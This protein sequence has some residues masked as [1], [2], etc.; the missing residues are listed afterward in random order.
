MVKNFSQIPEKELLEKILKLNEIDSFNPMQEKVLSQNL[1]NSNIVV[2]A[3]TA[4]GKTLV[5]EIAALNS[6]INNR[7]KVVYTCPLRALAN[8]HYTEFKRKYSDSLNIKATISTGDFDSSSKHL[9]NYDIIF[10]THEKCLPFDE[11][12]VCKDD[13]NLRIVKI[14]EFFEE[15]YHNAKIIKMK[16]K[17]TLIPKKKYFSVSFDFNKKEPVFSEIE[18][19]T[20]SAN[21]DK[22]LELKLQSGRMLT[23]T[24][25]HTLFRLQ[26]AELEK[27]SAEDSLGSYLTA[28]SDSSILLK[29]KINHFNVFEQFVENN[30]DNLFYVTF[31]SVNFEEL[32]NVMVTKNRT[33]RKAKELAKRYL[34][35]KRMPASIA[36]KLK[37]I[38][39]HKITLQ[40][41]D[42]YHQL[43]SK[44]KLSKSFGKILGYFISE[45]SYSTVSKTHGYYVLRYPVINKW[46]KDDLIKSLE[47][48]KIPFKLH[49]KNNELAVKSKILYHLFKSF[50]IGKAANKKLPD[51]VFFAPKPF[52]IGL[53]QGL[54]NGDGGVNPSSI[55]Y[56]TKNKELAYQIS[57]LL[58]RFRVQT[59]I[60]PQKVKGYKDTYWRLNMYGGKNIERF[61]YLVQELRPNLMKKAIELASS[62]EKRDSMFNNLPARP[63][64][65]KNQLHSMKKLDRAVYSG[66][67]SNNRVSKTLA[68]SFSLKYNLKEAL[69]ICNYP[70]GF[71]KVK[72]TTTAKSKKFV[73]NIKT[74]AGN[75][76]TGNGI[77]IKNCDSLQR[78]NAEWLQDVGL[79]ILDEIHD[80]DSGRGPTLEIV[81][82]KFLFI[83][84][85][86]QILALSA[87]IPNCKDIADWL[88]AELI[89]SDYRPMKL[90]EGVFFQN[91]ITY[92]TNSEELLSHDD[93]LSSIITDTL[94]NKKKQALVFANT[95]RNAEAS[96]RKL[97]EITYS[98]LTEKEKAELEKAS[99][100]ILDVLEAP[101]EQ[102]KKIAELL[103]KGSCFHHAGL[104][105]KQRTVIEDEFK[106]NNLKVISATPTLA[107]GINLPAHTVVISSVYRYADSGMEK[108]PVRDYKQMAGRSGRPKYDTEGR[109]IMIA[110]NALEAEDLFERYVNGRVEEVSSHLGIESV[111]R[112]H[113]LSLIA[114]NFVFDLDSM[115]KFF[116]KTFY[117]NQFGNLNE[118][119]SK[120]QSLLL[121]L[122]EMEFVTA[123]EKY[124]QA[125]KLGKRV[126]ELY[127]DPKSA[128][129]MIIALKKQI[130]FTPETYL[131]S[132]S[133]TS[134][135]FPWLN[136]PKN[137]EPEVWEFM[138]EDAS[139]IPV[140]LERAMYSDSNILRKYYL[141]LLLNDW[142]S[143]KREQDLMKQYNIQPGILYSKLQI[144]EWLCYSLFEL[145]KL[146]GTEN[147]IPPLG[148]MQK[149][150]KYGV[151]EELLI[152]TELKGIGRVRARALKRA[153]FESIAKIKQAPI[154]RLSDVI[155]SKTAQKLKMQLRV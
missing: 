25:D 117:A 99:K 30:L 92:N 112:M 114:N 11:Y 32:T 86:I 56:S 132:I 34:K 145:S 64:F 78:H 150:L 16:N 39:I 3:P 47:K 13:N 26:N 53:L 110:K 140:D 79:L 63:L 123:D 139:K 23:T 80:L 109:A 96:A 50:G 128:H 33:K 97:S 87:T 21:K 74:K 127:L 138:Q 44:I 91:E 8:E 27:V 90:K 71:L 41:S 153:G 136:V 4:S 146:I 72:T 14:G 60:Y 126:S 98:L 58:T 31:S 52:L 55:D 19:V 38:K 121:E 84:P 95:R 93:S 70:L 137:A 148:K 155:G 24:S 49:E 40:R 118:I 88:N 15:I 7:K 83:N 81:T 108:I 131:F 42:S 2:S 12:I 135:F 107:A 18:A 17:I 142:I 45:G 35:N 22:L 77:L 1:F 57:L 89:E 65:K 66:W 100:K 130:P 61:L 151:K 119:Y 143:E 103:K 113:L 82:T 59:Y 54:F 28:L 149:R 102:C 69:A 94:E 29:S 43:N 122:Q 67:Y 116:S 37:N 152:L 73:Y 76:F 115:E 125:T 101:T 5:S 120:L 133:D 75:Y 106:K 48:E 154:E 46:I 141:S 6:I 124:F 9:Q 129:K 68:K 144:A 36:K 51:F 111:L 85:K 147:H 105:Q 10:T 134:E 104:M 20:K 62:K